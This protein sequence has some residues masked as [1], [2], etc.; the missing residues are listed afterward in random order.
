MLASFRLSGVVYRA[1][2]GDAPFA[3]NEA[4]S[5]SIECEGQVE[6]DHYWDALV[7]GGEAGQCG[8]L[9]DR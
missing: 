4:F 7:D 9:R 2:G 8:W 3:L 1:I 6:V 5:L